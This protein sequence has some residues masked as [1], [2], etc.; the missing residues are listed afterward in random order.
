M[1]GQCHFQNKWLLMPEFAE[2]LKPG[3]TSVVGWCG[4]C[5]KEINVSGRGIAN[6]RSHATGKCHTENAKTI[7]KQ[8]NIAE[9]MKKFIRPSSAEKNNSSEDSASR[10]IVAINPTP[11][12]SMQAVLAPSSTY[13]DQVTTAEI[14]F[15]LKLVA[16][17]TSL[18]FAEDLNLLLRTAFPDSELIRGFQM[19]DDKAAYVICH[20]LAVFFERKNSSSIANSKFLVAQFD[21]SLNKISQRSQMDLHIRFIND[22][23]L[24]EAMYLTSAFLGNTTADD[25]LKA[26]KS[27]FPDSQTLVK[28]IQLGMDGPNVNWKMANLFQDELNTMPKS[29]QLINIGSCGL[30]IIHG[31]FKTGFEK[32]T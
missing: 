28:V 20:G 25:L 22:D 11:S 26:L 30:H 8:V 19:S 16:G 12:T 17:H 9:S 4:Y 7:A 10:Q 5:M 2:W 31:A 6:V 18:R 15:A 32:S 24:V 1:P 29:V 13:R 27:C 3:K 23:N 21:E 14:L